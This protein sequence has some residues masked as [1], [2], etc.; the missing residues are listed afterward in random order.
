MSTDSYPLGIE[1]GRLTDAQL[2]RLVK[3]IDPSHVESKRGL[4]Y[5]AQHEVR[6]ELTR[7][8]GFG[9]WDSSVTEMQLVYE[10]DQMG[11]ADDG[12]P[13]GKNMD[14][15]YY[16]A[17]YRARVHLHIRSLDG[18]PVAEFDEW[19]VEAN[20]PLPNRGEAHAMAV[21]SVESYALRRAAI[22]L[23]DRFGLGLYDKGQTKPLVKNSLQLL[24]RKPPAPPAE[25]KEVE[26]VTVQMTVT[27][28]EPGSEE[29]S[30]AAAQAAA[31]NAL[32]GAFAHPQ[33]R[34]GPQRAV[35]SRPDHVH[36][37][38]EQSFMSPGP[39]AD[40]SPYTEGPAI[41]P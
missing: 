28:V 38:G 9:N 41:E 34:R 39:V 13:N 21:T 40:V 37:N 15:R 7:I 12:G 22:G 36:T 10:Y 5:M 18:K 33:G 31:A 29:A 17:C 19:H 6:A 16:V 3:A 8:F 23:G 4:A 11:S 2:A 35:A 25:K 14:K 32:A 1:R 24:D 20:S 30:A 27:G 26:G